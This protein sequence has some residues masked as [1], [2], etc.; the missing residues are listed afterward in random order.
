MAPSRV[1]PKRAAH[2]SKAQHQEAQNE[3][4]VVDAIKF[5]KTRRAIVSARRRAFGLEPTLIS[6]IND[7]DS[8]R[9]HEQGEASKGQGDMDRQPGAAQGSRHPETPLAHR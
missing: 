7:A 3:Q 1:G 8:S 4:P 6:Q 9:K 2:D 5:F